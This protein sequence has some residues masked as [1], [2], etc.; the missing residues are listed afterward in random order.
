[1]P[2]KG[3]N[4]DKAEEKLRDAGKD[5]NELVESWKK[6]S[7]RLSTANK[8]IAYLCDQQRKELGEF[9]LA[10]ATEI[11]SHLLDGVRFNP[12]FNPVWIDEAEAFLRGEGVTFSGSE[13]R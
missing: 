7:G 10:K 2:G 6:D 1:M 4:M 11:I 12:W 13:K 9:K 3:G 8:R 5:W